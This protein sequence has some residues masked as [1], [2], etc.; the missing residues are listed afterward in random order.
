M[1]IL[2]DKI[3]LVVE[4]FKKRAL[5]LLSGKIYLIEVFGSFA[6][7]EA[8]ENSD[9]DLMVVVE[10]PASQ[11]YRSLHSLAIDILF[12][13]GVF[14]SLKIVDRASYNRMERMGAAFLKNVRPDAIELWRAA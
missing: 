12:D 5:T 6:R 9:L 13:T 3:K 7:G 8:R 11:T 2:D 14:I 1:A 4:E 10:R